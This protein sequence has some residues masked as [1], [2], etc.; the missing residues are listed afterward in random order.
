MIV[1]HRASLN[2]TIQVISSGSFGERREERQFREDIAGTTMA[3]AGTRKQM[4][5]RPENN[6]SAL[7]WLRLQVTNFNKS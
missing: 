6:N 7:L 4:V 3:G 5:T 1:G 2:S